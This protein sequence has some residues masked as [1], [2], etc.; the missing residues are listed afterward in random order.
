MSGPQLFGDHCFRS[1]CRQ[2]GFKVFRSRMISS[3]VLLRSCISTICGT[4]SRPR[5]EID[6]GVGSMVDEDEIGPQS[7]HSSK[8][9]QAKGSNSGQFQSV[10]IS[11][12]STFCILALV[13]G[14]AFRILT[15]GSSA[16]RLVGGTVALSHKFCRRSKLREPASNHQ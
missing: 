11:Q 10:C 8:A 7:V 1:S 14:F 5:N 12:G 2:H 9:A 6:N 3:I 15:D 16:Q 13:E 4:S